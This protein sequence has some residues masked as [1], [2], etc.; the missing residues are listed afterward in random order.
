MKY[1]VNT[2]CHADHITSGGAIK[3]MCPE[4]KTLISEASKARADVK[5]LDG[6]LVSFGRYALRA[7]ATPGHT[8][9]CAMARRASDL[10]Y[11]IIYHIIL[12]CIV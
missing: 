6:D 1:V 4:V 12:Y 9:G 2:H 11:H 5:L 3:K 10:I 8:D 7:V